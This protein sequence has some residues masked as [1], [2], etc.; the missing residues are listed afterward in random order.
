MKK[1]K[2]FIRIILVSF[3]IF[4]GSF[5]AAFAQNSPPVIS[6]DCDE[7]V[8]VWLEGTSYLYFYASD[9]DPGDEKNWLFIMSPPPHTSYDTTIT[10][11]SNGDA[12][13]SYTP[14]MGT[15]EGDFFVTARVTDSQG[16]YDECEAEFFWTS[17]PKNIRI[18]F[19]QDQYQGQHCYVPVILNNFITEVYG[20][21]FLIGYD[22]SA[23]AINSAIPGEIFECITSR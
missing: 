1:N 4:A 22:A 23:I 7:V 18:D 17:P 8:G 9:A 11:D 6:G 14:S 15:S 5:L 16:A 3:F 19:I 20:F 2:M 13:L 21:D 12:V 10:I